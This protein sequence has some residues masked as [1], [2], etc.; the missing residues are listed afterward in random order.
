M[1]ESDLGIIDGTH[2]P[3]LTPLERDCL[4]VLEERGKGVKSAISAK[5]FAAALSVDR[6]TT[7]K[8]DDDDGTEQ[9]EQVAWGTRNLRKLINH[10]I[11]T[12]GIPIVCKAG[13][14]GGYF[15]PGSTLEISEFYQTFHRRAMTGLVKASRGKRSAFVEIVTQLSL[16]FDEPG[17]REIIEKLRL[18]PDEDTV[19]AWVQ[20]VTKLLDRIAED[21][22]KYAGEIRRIQSTYGD[23]FVPREKVRLLKE[24][25]AEFQRLLREIA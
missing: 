16:G 12:H 15:L 14:G 7:E 5:A 9:T 3:E 23:I 25:T 19:P 24:K 13:L 22:Q 6:T 17:N 21:P 1:Q 20:V 2:N 4:S 11:M 10:L 18:H 8:N